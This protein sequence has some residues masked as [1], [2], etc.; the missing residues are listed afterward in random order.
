VV[1][2]GDDGEPRLDFLP[3]EG[4]AHGIGTLVWVK[5][6]DGTIN[7]QWPLILG[8]AGSAGKE[9]GILFPTRHRDHIRCRILV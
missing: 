7:F 2:G 4:I 9:K 1:N 8:L 3:M 5:L 6:L